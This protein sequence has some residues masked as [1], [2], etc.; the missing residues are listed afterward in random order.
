LISFKKLAVIHQRWLPIGLVILIHELCQNNSSKISRSQPIDEHFSNQRRR[1]FDGW[2]V[3][4]SRQRKI[5]KRECT[6]IKYGAVW[7]QSPFN[8][9]DWQVTSN[10]QFREWITTD[11]DQFRLVAL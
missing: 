8:P 5:K 3:S 6:F 9:M 10:R 4:F 7:T 11:W 1:G 2:M